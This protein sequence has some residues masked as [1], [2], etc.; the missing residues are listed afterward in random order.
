MLYNNI[1]VR[2]V[3][4]IQL[5]C[6]GFFYQNV[7]LI[8]RKHIVLKTHSNYLN[9]RYPKWAHHCPNLLR[10]TL[11]SAQNFMNGN[12][13]AGSSSTNFNS[14]KH[15]YQ[16]TSCSV[17]FT[18]TGLTYCNERQCDIPFRAYDMASEITY[19]GPSS[20]AV[21]LKWQTRPKRV[22]F[23][24]KP[25]PMVLEEV[26]NALKY[27]WVLGLEIV[28]E[29][30]MYLFLESNQKMS[31]LFPHLSTSYNNNQITQE[32]AGHNLEDK[33]SISRLEVFNPTDPA[34]DFILTF[35]GDG[36]L[37]H[38]NTLFNGR[39]IPPTMSFDFGSLGFMAPFYYEDFREEIDKIMAGSALLTLR[40]RLDCTIIKNN[41]ETATFSVLNEAVIDRGP[42]PYL[43]VL[44]VTCDSQYL[45]TV[46]GDG[47][48]I[49]T[50][51]GSTAYSLAAGGCIVY[52][53]VPAI[54]LTPICAH[55]LSFR[56]ML[57]PDSSV[58]VCTVPIEC[59]T[60]GWVSF[61]G[62]HRQELMK[63]DQLEIRMSQYPM[64]TINRLNF[65]GDWFD[66]L[67]AGFMF[68]VRPRQKSN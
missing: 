13:S 15:K 50:P 49:A 57:L 68:N 43:S 17:P 67:R 58:L 42:S 6:F 32:L 62:K 31:F 21:M 12:M 55:T 40:M 9:S 63:G 61:D 36:L 28:V 52:P 35:G 7:K 48:I 5:A 66:A 16:L 26:M 60:S 1:L 54:L 18:L 20:H 38:C 53:S 59:R 10:M 33:S 4:L 24:S 14:H 51:T 11:H 2:L 25:D 46:Q 65:T 3:L 23:L 45:T 34:I 29:D 64:P 39:N 44:D 47:I 41:T 19:A 56:P 37:L 8:N 22:L 30:K 27:L